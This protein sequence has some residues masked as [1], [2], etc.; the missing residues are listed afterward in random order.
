MDK[1]V[2]I[3]GALAGIGRAAA[4]AF[5]REGASLILSGRNE[6][7][8]RAL[9]DEIRATGARAEFVRAD[10]RSDEQVAALFDRAVREFGRVD[11]VVN[12]AGTEG[13]P[14]RL[15]EQTAESLAATFETNVAG[16]L[17]GLKH[18]FRVMNGN[19]GG[20]VVNI[21]STYGH[22][23]GAGA[24]VYAASKHA[25]EG[26]TKSAA[27]EGA[28]LGIRVNAVAPGPVETA[29]LDRFAGSRQRAQQMVAAVPIGRLGRPEDI[30][31]AISFLASDRASFITGQILGV[32]GGKNA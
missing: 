23:G 1:I 15:T 28:P 25:V 29:M 9:A 27:L 5:A 8:G 14:G 24:S 6:E 11:V 19:G 18:A 13:Q 21:S 32:D 2:V 30:A 26:L 22:R 20:A 4:H 16:T 12:N 31:E 7:A 17:F 3:T 10:V